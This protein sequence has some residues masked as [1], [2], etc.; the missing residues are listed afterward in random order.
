MNLTKPKEVRE[1]LEVQENK[2]VEVIIQDD[3]CFLKDKEINYTLP[4]TFGI[5]ELPMVEILKDEINL[6]I[7]KHR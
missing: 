2:P 5:G 6:L 4:L 3:V 7:L 1:D